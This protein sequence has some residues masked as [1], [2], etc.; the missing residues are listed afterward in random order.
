MEICAS[1]LQSVN[2]AYDNIVDIVNSEGGWTVYGW[3][4][5]GLINDV[6]Q[7]VNPIKETYDNKFLSQDISTNVV[8]IYPPKIYY[9]NVSTINGRSL[10]NLKFHFYTL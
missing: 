3:V 7:L 8:H 4:K 9:L 1:R 2:Y 10:D 6:S 5:I